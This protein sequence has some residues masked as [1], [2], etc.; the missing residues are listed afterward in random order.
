[1]PLQVDWYIPHRV[2]DVRLWGVVTTDDILILAQ[3]YVTMLTE[4]ELQA[5]G[6]SVYLLFD[7]LEA[8]SMPPIYRMMKEGLTVLRFT[9]RGPAFHISR[10]NAIRRIVDLA[11][12]VSPFQL[13]SCTN[14][15]EAIAMLQT[16]LD[17]DQTKTLNDR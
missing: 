12:Y 11:A 17:K 2:I 10:N 1:M 13:Y 5:A 4:A 3:N 16:M 9:N 8:Q 15:A 7:T 14:R 6:P